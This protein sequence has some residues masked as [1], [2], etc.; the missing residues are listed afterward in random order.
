MP[1][2]PSTCN[3]RCIGDSSQICGGSWRIS[4]YRNI[5]ELTTSESARFEPDNTKVITTE[6]DTAEKNSTRYENTKFMEVTTIEQS[7]LTES[8]SIDSFLLGKQWPAMPQTTKVAETTTVSKITTMPEITTVPVTTLTEI[9]EMNITGDTT[10]PI[11]SNYSLLHIT[12]SISVTQSNYNEM[13]SKRNII[14][15]NFKNETERDIKVLLEFNPLVFDAKVSLV[16]VTETSKRRK[17]STPKIIVKFI[18]VCLI[19]VTKIF[20][21]NEI[22]MAIR[23]EFKNADLNI[24]ETFDENSIASLK[25]QCEI[26]KIINI[27]AQSNSEINELQGF[28]YENTIG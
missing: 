16:E 2:K 28:Y 17:R 15:Q 9:N 12:G 21:I 19:K 4:V 11:A 20:A 6:Y 7:T 27:K 23:S 14:Y 13:E 5:R 25:I 26:P 3:K 24:L 1:V 8:S 18:A 10:T 22:Q